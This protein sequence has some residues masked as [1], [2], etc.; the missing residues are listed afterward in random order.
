MCCFLR[1]VRIAATWQ[2]LPHDA[3]SLAWLENPEW[4]GSKYILEKGL[5]WIHFSGCWWMSIDLTE[6]QKMT[7][8]H[9]VRYLSHRYQYINFFLCF[10]IWLA[11]WYSTP[12]C[13]LFQISKTWHFCSVSIGASWRND[14]MW[15]HAGN[16]NPCFPVMGFVG[17]SRDWNCDLEN[18]RKKWVLGWTLSWT[19]SCVHQPPLQLKWQRP[20]VRIACWSWLIFL[21]TSSSTDE[22]PLLL[23]VFFF[24]WQSGSAKMFGKFGACFGPCKECLSTCFQRLLPTMRKQLR[25]SLADGLGEHV[26]PH[27]DEVESGWGP[28]GCVRCVCICWFSVFFLP[29]KTSSCSTGARTVKLDLFLTRFGLDFFRFFYVF[30]FEAAQKRLLDGLGVE[31][32][33]S[34]S[35]SGWNLGMFDLTSSCTKRQR[36]VEPG[37]P[38]LSNQW[39]IPWSEKVHPCCLSAS[40]H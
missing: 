38:L 18:L 15:W 25:D 26:L 9:F 5:W 36:I 19:V 2:G 1:L 24:F 34:G 3:G 4:K 10:A 39:A 16:S 35:P 29:E 28:M 37:F 8:C 23:F 22:H 20:C 14:N 13:G 7:P 12:S 31:T 21:R 6:I 11:S 33:A 32:L 30:G 17:F 27:L 40:K